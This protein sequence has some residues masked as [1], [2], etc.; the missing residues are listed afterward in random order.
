MSMSIYTGDSLADLFGAAQRTLSGQGC[1]LDSPL[2]IFYKSSARHS[3]CWQAGVTQMLALPHPESSWSRF[4]P[5]DQRNAS[6]CFWPKC[7]HSIIWRIWNARVL[8][9]K[10]VVVL[11]EESL[12]CLWVGSC[13]R[14]R[15]YQSWI[16]FKLCCAS[17]PLSEMYLGSCCV[18]LECL[19]HDQ[20]S[21][22]IQK[23]IGVDS[24]LQQLAG[25]LPATRSCS[26]WL[27]Y[28]VV[29]LGRYVHVTWQ[30][31]HTLC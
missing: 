25:Q 31:P 4:K 26:S 7:V 6:K 1:S 23:P 8:M 13:T 15:R 30:P 22:I 21:S 9:S 18:F 5:S 29:P 2:V 12:C 10:F 16:S 17:R 24:G 3:V 28:W 27:A 19:P 20:V 11:H 14:F